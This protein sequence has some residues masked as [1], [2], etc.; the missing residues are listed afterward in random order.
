M[1]PGTYPLSSGQTLLSGTLPFCQKEVALIS[2][3]TVS[4]C[5]P[6]AKG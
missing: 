1:I 5:H 4:D 2:T 6:M 3:S